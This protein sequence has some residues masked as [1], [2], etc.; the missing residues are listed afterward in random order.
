[1]HHTA[2]RLVGDF[3]GE[4]VPTWDVSLPKTVQG[5]AKFFFF[6]PLFLQ[7]SLLKTCFCAWH[8]PEGVEA[9]G[10]GTSFAAKNEPWLQSTLT[11]FGQGIRRQESERVVVWINYVACGVVPAKKIQF[12]VEQV[13][14]V[15]HAFPK[16]A[17]AII[18]LP[19]R[20]ADLRASPKLLGLGLLLNLF[21]LFVHPPKH[22][23]LFLT[24]HSNDPKKAL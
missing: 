6:V 7:L 5:L 1:M 22:G 14:Q 16:N 20:A 11:A 17:A 13:T 18:L 23:C 24:G 2:W 3:V 8:T 15:L 9:E 4:T 21:F 12:T 19:N 10:E